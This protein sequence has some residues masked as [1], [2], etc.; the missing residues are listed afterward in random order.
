M[1][2]VERF[3]SG[4]HDYIGRA[5]TPLAR[6]LDELEQR[7]PVQVKGDKGDAGQ[8]G[9]NADEEAI[10]HR[11]VEHLKV[12]F[13]APKDGAAGAAGK[14]AYA[15][16][17]ERG[18]A[19]TELQWLDSL[20]GSPGEPGPRGERGESVQGPQGERGIKGDDGKSIQGEKGEKGD[21][22]R[23]EKGEV[24]PTGPVAEI[25]YERVERDIR[26][27]VSVAVKEEVT[28]AVALLP[29]ARDGLDG[30]DAPAVDEQA[31]VERVKALIPTPRD[32]VNGVN[33]KDATVDEEAIV[34][35]VR[36]LIP[37]PQDGRDAEPIDFEA[38]VAK[39]VSL[40]PVPT[41]GTNGV[42]G[43][44]VEIDDL[45]PIME[46]ET[47]RW[48]LEFERRATDVLRDAI[49]KMP[50]PK[51]GADGLNALSVEDFDVTLE[52]RVFTFALRCGERIVEKKIKVP[53]PQDCGVYRVG[54]IHEKG[55]VVTFGG[56]QWISLTDE[57]KTKPP[58]DSW[59]LCVSRGKDGRDAA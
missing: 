14:S 11:V 18:F 19:G 50:K 58:S 59:R 10:V 33:G 17:V 48:Q 28:K 40:I 47:A 54:R 16:A 2:N 24:G 32:G 53:Y 38:V 9:K 3:V 21:S 36:A 37:T 4:L 15:L 56:S 6:R 39:A 35:R 55:D 8:D 29:V 5:L 44:S 45:R 46:A 12:H 51:D 25:D 30:K 41:N 7:A 49:E 13:P 42:D 43:K 23:G 27:V 22:I 20:K 26:E 34:E 57:N 52:G 31:I 1:F